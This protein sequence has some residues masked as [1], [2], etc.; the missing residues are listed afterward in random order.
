MATTD[1]NGIAHIEGTDP[2]KPLQGLFNTISSSVSNVVG[3]LRKQVIYPVKTRWDAQNKVDELKRQGVE[4]TADE[5]I[6][7]NIL[8]D[9]IQ[10][11]HDGSG[12]TY[13]SAQMAVLAAGVFETGYQRWEQHK[14]KSFTVPFPEELDRIP[15]SLLCQV[16]DAITHNI[17]AFPVDKK[18]FGVAAACNWPWPV[19]SNVHV[20]WVALG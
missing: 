14:I 9:R 17:I 13:F 19:D 5:P 20:S 8:N 1:S 6:V 18:Q 4:G 15:R 16:T 10:L 3:K 11:Q 7:F 2:V 12:F